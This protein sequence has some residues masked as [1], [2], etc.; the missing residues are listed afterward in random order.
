MALLK[1]EKEKQNDYFVC[2]M[3]EKHIKQEDL[4]YDSELA[5]AL[6]TNEICYFVRSIPITPINP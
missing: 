4:F 2:V 5:K 6:K 1:N 3:C